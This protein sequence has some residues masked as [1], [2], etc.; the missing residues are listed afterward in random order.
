MIT[1][2][3][4]S[5][6]AGELSPLIHLRSDLEKYRNGCRTLQNMLIT[7]YGGVRRRPGLSYTA[8]AP[9]ISRLFRFQATI[10]K[11]FILEMSAG[12]L[13][14]YLRD[15]LI[16]DGLDP[17]EVE[18]P[19]DE[20]D[21]WQV[22]MAQINNVAYFVHP[23]Y[24][25]HKL[26]RI[27]DANWEFL[28]VEFSYPAMLEENLRKNRKFTTSAAG[29]EG[30]TIEVESTWSFFSAKHEGAYLQLS[31]EREA[32]QFQ[33]DLEATSGNDGLFSD[34]LIVQGAWNL[35]T[36]GT[37]TG[38]FQLQRNLGDGSGWK[39]IRTFTSAAD[40][41]YTAGNTEPARC[42][43]RL[44]WIHGSAGSSSPKA[45]LEASGSFIRGLVKIV[46]VVSDTLA[47]CE[48]VQPVEE[49][50]TSY[51]RES[52]WSDKRGWPRTVAAH[53]QRL[54]FGG[55]EHRP[56]TVWAS[57]VDDYED[58]EPG[59]E[60]SDSWSHTIVSGQQ[61]DIQ[62]LV[63]HKSL[64]VGTSGDEWVISATKEEAIITPTNVRA[65]RHSGN[66]SDF[67]K[68][69]LLDDSL[70]FVQQGGKVVREMSYAFEA[71]GYV[72]TDLTLLAE[73]ITGDGIIDMAWQA[74]PESI[75]WC[76]T[77]GGD[78]IALTYEK[79][80][81]VVGWH[82]HTTG[83]AS[84]GFESVAVKS[85]EGESDQ[86]WVV[87]RRTIDG[88]V[89]RYVERFK[90]DGFFLEEPW[91]MLY[92][93]IEG[94]DLWSYHYSIF[95]PEEFAV[96]NY[97]VGADA[98]P[99][100]DVGAHAQGF[101]MSEGQV[102]WFEFETESSSTSTPF[103]GEEV[104]GY[105]FTPFPGWDTDYDVG[106]LVVRE[107]K[108]YRCTA[109]HSKTD[110]DGGGLYKY[111]PGWGSAWTDVWELALDDASGAYAPSAGWSRSTQ[112][113]EVGDRV[114]WNKVVMEAI[115]EHTPASDGLTAGEATLIT[116]ANATYWKRAQ[117]TYEEGDLVS[118]KG[119][120]YVCLEDHTPTAATRPGIG[121]DW[122]DKWEVVPTDN[123]I[124]YVDS[125][126]SLINPGEISEM[127]GLDHLEGETVQVV[128]NGAVL[129]PRV[130]SS[131]AIQFDQ[132]GDPTEFTDVC[133]GLAYE[134]I[135]E[136]MAL[137][138]GMQN[139]TSVSREKRIHELVIYFKDS[140]GCKASDRVNGTFDTL[141]FYDT[142]NA[143]SPQLFTGPKLHK[144]DSR[145]DL[146][147]S[148]VLKQDLPMPM[149][150]LAVVPK[151]N[152]Y[153]DNS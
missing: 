37:W 113:Y 152:V 149:R 46:T 130:V 22:Q 126:V 136:P 70:L 86:V 131:G 30:D 73:H 72:T 3:I 140:Y 10:A 98:D 8:T 94:V 128:A 63:S 40:A 83:T 123:L 62:W 82:R 57:A 142:G 146:E 100:S 17:Y 27:G 20:D 51:W 71:D 32:D 9:G 11:G 55:N 79:S 16:M 76:V 148:F 107:G 75:L 151:W 77:R 21:L 87:V 109:Y 116:P 4:P 101:V 99:I 38:T 23:L 41:N 33:V 125:G 29:E 12:K 45:V 65:R 7:P 68:A 2:L 42:R 49:G 89:R 80:Q 81:N 110:T 117:G 13:R 133:A 5:F 153:G 59:E 105:D 15:G 56:Q 134:S 18:S 104:F 127:T 141:A 112:T 50:E 52:A 93:D 91:S 53:E 95:G 25:V 145:T 36:S 43:M 35:T 122:G 88:T 129:S 85:V 67:I 24:P 74:Q 19:Y 124:F 97:P 84:D 147:A 34:E 26:S 120:N 1:S 78:L 60:D 96:W 39:T 6:N 102:K 138:V 114:V 115:L 54:V 58:F 121:A 31:H 132:E 103:P 14:F 47:Q 66:G 48:V 118:S 106:E 135:L 150:V 139:G 119:V 64:I 143:N 111:V 108:M 44:K 137:E 144:L 61:N 92:P 28:P 69:R 90:P